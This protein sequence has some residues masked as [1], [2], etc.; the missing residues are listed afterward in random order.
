MQTTVSSLA[1]I[2][3]P[4]AIPLSTVVFVGPLYA[5]YV[6][7]EVAESIFSRRRTLDVVNDAILLSLYT[8]T[9]LTRVISHRDQGELRS[10]ACE[11]IRPRPT[12][13][14]SAVVS[15]FHG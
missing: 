12:T 9:T 6:V 8:P 3:G 5:K 15:A 4:R 11:R 10:R 14:Y 1:S 7:D 13:T 2:A